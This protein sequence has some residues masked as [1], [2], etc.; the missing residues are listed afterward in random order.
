MSDLRVFHLQEEQSELAEPSNA[1]ASLEALIVKICIS[2]MTTD[3]T[4]SLHALARLNGNSRSKAS[5]LASPFKIKQLSQTVYLLNIIHRL[6]LDNRQ[7]N[8][9]ELFYRSLSD[10]KAPVFVDQS[11]MNRALF[12][13]LN[14]VGCDRHELGIFT[15]ARGIAAADPTTQTICL[16]SRGDFVADLSDHP[17]GISIS[18]SLCD[19]CTLQTTAEFVLV[20]EKD[21]VFQSLLSSRNFFERN[22]CILITAR[23]YP[24]NITIR[25]TRK[26]LKIVGSKLPLLY[27][28]DLDPHGVSIALVYNKALEGSLLW[29]GLHH[30]DVIHLDHSRVLGMKMKACDLALLNGLIENQDTPECYRT[31]LGK[32]ETRGLKYEVECLHS[33]DE[34]YLASVWLPKKVQFIL[35]SIS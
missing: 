11:S 24:D 13:L 2:I 10:D 16:D 23:G 15:T 32:L 19:I 4:S 27:L 21:T 20:V 33:V 25:F 12:C 1:L 28:G 14:A 5:P 7:V 18:E 22:K 30:E 6:C 17:E 34:D 29:I 35:L 9:R 26:L 8:Q 31:Q 3:E